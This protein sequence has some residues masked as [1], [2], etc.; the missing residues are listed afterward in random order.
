MST[1]FRHDSSFSTIMS[2]VGDLAVI[3]IL[4]LVGSLPLVTIGAS[5]AALFDTV[6][7][8]EAG[9]DAHYIR[10][11]WKAYRTNIGKNILLSLLFFA[12]YGLALFNLWYLGQGAGGTDFAA[13]SY[14][15]NIAIIIVVAVLTVF[16]FPFATRTPLSVLAHI[17]HAATLA[18][19]YP[20]AAVSMTLINAI[21][22]AVLLFVPGG[23]SFVLF[24][25]GLLFTGM[26]AW[27]SV[28]IMR[29]AG[30]FKD[31]N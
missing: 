13:L 26:S 1:V 18:L 22:L 3:N 12:F 19:R 20:K 8:L 6:R 16:V 15:I 9:D 29:S 2:T 10:R 28:R 5:T 27:F 17:K 31:E 11:F 24:F 14:G 30:M 7:A 4:W 21:P 25:W 23:F